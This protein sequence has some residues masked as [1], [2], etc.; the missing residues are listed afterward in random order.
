MLQVEFADDVTRRGFAGGRL[1]GFGLA[2]AL[3][4]EDYALME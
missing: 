4:I 1:V 3:R 2:M